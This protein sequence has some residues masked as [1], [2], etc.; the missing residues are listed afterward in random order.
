MLYIALICVSGIIILSMSIQIDNLKKEL[1]KH[2]I[3]TSDRFRRNVEYQMDFENYINEKELDVLYFN[4]RKLNDVQKDLFLKMYRFI[5]VIPK[6]KRS[7]AYSQIMRT[8]NKG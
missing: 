1:K 4:F 3:L 5:D 7:W 8:L 6:E 2:E